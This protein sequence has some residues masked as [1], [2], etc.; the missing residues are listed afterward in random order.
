MSTRPAHHAPTNPSF[1]EEDLTRLAGARS[2]ARGRGYLSDVAELSATDD[3]ITATVY[4]TEPYH[5]VLRPACPRLT[6]SCD[7]P[8]G[9]DGH[10]CKHCVAVGLTALDQWDDLPRL[11]AETTRRAQTLDEWLDSLDRDQL[12]DL[13]REQLATDPDLHRRLELRAA[14]AGSDTPAVRAQIRRLLDTRPFEQYGVVDRR[15][16]AGYA[17][18]L[19][20]AA[21]A[22]RALATT[23]LD[24]E[25]VTLAESA[26]SAIGEAAER[27]DDS[28]GDL[29]YAAEEMAQ[30]HLEACRRLRPDPV[31]TATWLA[32]HLLG[33]WSHLP[34]LD[35]AEYRDILGEPGWAE[36][37]RLAREAHRSHPSGWTE[38][39]VL[40]SVLK[41]D[42]SV[43]ELVAALSADL[44]PN[45]STHLT[46]ALELDRAGRR[47]EAATWAERGLAETEGTPPRDRRLVEFLAHHYEQAGRPTDLVRVRRDDFHTLRTLDTYRSLRTACRAADC[48]SVERPRALDLL[49]TDALEDQINCRP[50]TGPVLIEAL[51]DDGDA[52]AAW[53]AAPSVPTTPAQ[54]VRLAD[55]VRD[56]HPADALPIYLR[57]I[58]PLQQQT[59]HPAYE[60]MTELLLSARAC[61]RARGTEAEFTR[62]LADLRAHQKRKRNLLRMLDE[63]GL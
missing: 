57:A 33:D 18:Q 29:S 11:S 27:I 24:V 36:L 25:A 15:D 45:G 1:T 7:C 12:R 5:V 53:E 50:H 49:R 17:A 38:R 34:E 3:R 22:I 20:E 39:Y 58:T 21:L 55:A 61:H 19:T 26:I 62:Y 46:I 9:Q 31:R 13:L 14:A 44:E 48:W 52:E 32:A 41:A 51:L 4:G 60:R 37:R 23:E 54:W 56:R 63:H 59:G 8:Y 40:E 42:G 47:D 2:F 43:D 35:P 6:G 16:A 30:V 28:D 10:F